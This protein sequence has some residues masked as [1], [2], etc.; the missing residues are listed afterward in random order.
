MSVLVQRCLSER[1]IY[2]LSDLLA[3]LVRKGIQLRDAVDGGAHLGETTQLLLQHIQGVVYA[4]EPAADAP[5][6]V[7]GNPR[8]SWRRLALSNRDST[9]RLATPSGIA[10][11]DL[12]PRGY[13]KGGITPAL[14][15]LYGR[16]VRRESTHVQEVATVRGA[17]DLPSGAQVDFIKLDLQGS[18]LRALRGLEG[19]LAHVEFMW[20][21][22]TGSQ[23]GILSFLSR[24]GFALFDS[25]YI[26]E[27]PCLRS[28][29][30]RNFTAVGEIEIAP[31]RVGIQA[32]RTQ[33]W[34]Y[35]APHF[36]FMKRT[37]GL[38]QTDLICIKGGIAH[39]L[40]DI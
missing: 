13:L 17:S 2:E 33:D 31:G 9:A 24:Q 32:R 38:M 26:F 37:Q 39:L 27:R 30:K 40:K 10:F 21:E 20:V 25:A 28:I 36:Q 34:R 14:K 12:N 22:Y 16:F 35:F 4:Y 6:G 8:V 15:E 5:G 1:G 11:G 19:T 29:S 7:L 23:P 3:A 18:E